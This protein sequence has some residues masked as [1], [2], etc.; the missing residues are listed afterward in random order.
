MRI[1]STLAALAL[2]A[3]AGCSTSAEYRA[4]QD[5][6]LAEY[7]AHAGK[8]VKTIRLYTGLD[9]W[10]AL[11]PDKLAIFIGVNRAYLLTLRAHCSGLEFQQQIGIS[12]TNDVIDVRFDKVYFEHQV[13]FL[14]EIRPIDYKAMKR[15]RL[16]RSKAE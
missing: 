15:E 2:A 9:R 16:A 11:A 1:K 4:R 7:E 14:A 12:S 6:R 13:C 5:A 3:I 10:D 8:P